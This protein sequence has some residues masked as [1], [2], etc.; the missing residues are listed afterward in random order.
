MLL[1]FIA[2]ISYSALYLGL[3]IEC[4]CTGKGGGKAGWLTI[5]RNTLLIAGT[6]LSV[7]LQPRRSPLAAATIST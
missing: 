2:A 4:G 6:L 3:T 7:Y 1:L 5:G